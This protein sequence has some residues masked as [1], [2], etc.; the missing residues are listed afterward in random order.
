MEDHK[1]INSNI[2]T[3]LLTIIE[4][5]DRSNDAEFKECLKTRKKLALLANRFD[6]Y[7][8]KIEFN[9]KE[10]MGKKFDK[11]II[12]VIF[13]LFEDFCAIG[14]RIHEI[15]KK[16][17]DEEIKRYLNMY[18]SYLLDF[19]VKTMEILHYLTFYNFFKSET[20]AEI[21]KDTPEFKNNISEN[22]LS[23]EI[24]VQKINKMFD[25]IHNKMDSGN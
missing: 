25:V 7:A 1:I 20:V 17:K 8:W 5:F 14:N 23:F 16:L 18:Y 15:S 2:Q 24:L 11:V 9:H 21:D 4:T 10:I 13:N 12:K 19:G 22:N 6:M 3:K